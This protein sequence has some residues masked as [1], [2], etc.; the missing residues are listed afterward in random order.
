MPDSLSDKLRR[1]TGTEKLSRVRVAQRVQVNAKLQPVAGELVFTLQPGV[2][3]G[4]RNALP[5]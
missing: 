2:E 4:R 1:D 5:M 3:R